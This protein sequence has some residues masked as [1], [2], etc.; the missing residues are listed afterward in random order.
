M[1]DGVIIYNR[2][3][4]IADG[5]MIILVKNGKIVDHKRF[6]YGYGI[7]WIVS[8]EVLESQKLLN[9]VI[10]SFSCNYEIP[11]YDLR[12]AKY[13]I[14]SGSWII[15]KH[16]KFYNLDN[17]RTIKDSDLIKVLK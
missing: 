16:K 12:N 11:A 9:E 3:G 8:Q 4:A 17:L 1:T 5:V 6:D 7:S 14:S 13:S 15:G 2:S 10:R